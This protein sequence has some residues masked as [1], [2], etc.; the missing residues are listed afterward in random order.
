MT[1][2]INMT[3][4]LGWMAV[5]ASAF[6]FY[7]S[8]L[9]IRWSQAHATIDP[10]FFVFARFFLGLFVVIVEMRWR[11]ATLQIH[12]YHLLFGRAIANCV[13]VYC[14]YK[15]VTL[16]TVAEA[17]ILNM[18]Y[19]LFIALF[20]ALFWPTQRDAVALVT[21][22]VAFSGVWLV[23]AP[24]RV[25]INVNNLWG[26]ASGATAA[27]AIIYLNV[28]R[29]YHDTHTI[30]LVMFTFGTVAVGLLFHQHLFIPERRELAYLLGSATV[31]VAGQYLLTVGF[32]YVTAVE[33]SIISS[34]RILLAAL[35][36]PLLAADP[37]LTWSGWLGAALIFGANV[38][39]ALRK[40]TT[41]PLSESTGQRF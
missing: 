1:L 32:R 40:S 9:I 8:T 16:T 35:L 21:V 15:A 2:P 34:T 27:A 33:G 31:G 3:P 10:S 11:R 36:G 7:L 23:L 19:P 14:F 39:L 18:T 25:G 38:V 12:S 41:A 13:A 28:S 24:A 20:T 4:V 17:N 29:R 5:F 26:L 6:F 22:L 37:P 30:L